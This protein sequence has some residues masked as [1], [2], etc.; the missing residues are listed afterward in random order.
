MAD[1]HDNE[2]LRSSIWIYERLDERY[3]LHG[4]NAKCSILQEELRDYS[5]I[6]NFCMNLT[7]IFTKFDELSLYHPFDNDN[8]RI[9]KYWIFDRLFNQIIKD[10]KN[11]NIGDILTKLF[12]IQQSYVKAKHCD[13]FNYPKIKDHFNTM[14]RVYDYATDYNAIDVYI[15]GKS[16]LCTENMRTFVNE[17]DESYKKVK[18]ECDT[19]NNNETYCAVLRHIKNWDVN[20]KLS[21]KLTCRGKPSPETEVATHAIGA[22]GIH[23]HGLGNNEQPSTEL[24]AEDTHIPVSTPVISVIFPLFGI[25]FSFFILYKFTTFR[26]S[27][28]ARFMRKVI[29]APQT[30]EELESEKEFSEKIYKQVN[31]D[32]ESSKCYIGYHPA[33]YP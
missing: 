29:S 20:K 32:S 8:C 23:L 21:N 4:N 7:G 33:E 12:P 28:H 25:L 14:K 10:D 17:N 11:K 19:S 6:K 27:L 18:A 3:K 1:I 30:D 24:H 13:L 9:V 31:R 15:V 22:Q 16:Y 2:L 5:G 26:R